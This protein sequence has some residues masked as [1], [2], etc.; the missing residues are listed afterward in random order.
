MKTLPISTLAPT[1]TFQVINFPSDWETHTEIR[2]LALGKYFP[3]EHQIPDAPNPRKASTK[4]PVYKAI[5]ESLFDEPERFHE[6]NMGVYLYASIKHVEELDDGVKAVTLIFNPG[7]NKDEIQ[8]GHADGRH[9]ML[10]LHDPSLKGV[11]LSAVRVPLTI[12]L[13]Q[14][15]KADK[16]IAS[17]RQI[18]Y[19]HDKKTRYDSEG[20]FDTIKTYIPSSWKVAYHQN[21]AD[22]SLD[23]RCS[24]DHILQVTG[25]A[26]PRF[27]WLN[28]GSNRFP[29]TY[30]TNLSQHYDSMLSNAQDMGNLIRD[31]GHLEYLFW[32]IA[33]EDKDNLLSGIP[34]IKIGS[35]HEIMH[36]N[37][38]YIVAGIHAPRSTVFPAISAFRVLIE[39][40]LS[41]NRWDW[42]IPW[43]EKYYRPLIKKLWLA[44]KEELHKWVALNSKSPL[45]NLLGNLEHWHNLHHISFTHLK[46]LEKKIINRNIGWNTVDIPITYK[47]N[48]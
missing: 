42:I 24:I 8:Q 33:R 19:R 36:A 39:F 7:V 45:R 35:Q 37:P 9:T 11:D 41:S 23:P 46:D 18:V 29:I 34:T 25:M 17:H 31:I 43:E 6:L 28:T 40:N 4:Q 20:K 21:Q 10:A 13:A 32:I 26:A 38:E 1:V 16:R 22:T 12:K 2:C 44:H 48:A 15:T 3:H 5:V 27:S 30:V 47:I 14:P